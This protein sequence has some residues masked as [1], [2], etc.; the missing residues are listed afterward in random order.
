M[1]S[2]KRALEILNIALKTGAEYAEIYQQEEIKRV[3]SV[4]F[5]RVD[6]VSTSLIAGIGLRL[7]KNGKQVY[8]YTSDLSLKSL[9][10]LAEQLSSSFEGEQEV[11]VKELNS[12][13]KK[14]INEVL[15]PIEDV[16]TEV[17]LAKLKLA[18]KAAYDVSEQIVNC[19]IAF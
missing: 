18:E 3:I 6:V 9:N 14:T 17:I 7:I 4:N 19:N 2:K 10:N 8:G 12:P 16:S 1:I 11:F 13:K 5:K 15:K